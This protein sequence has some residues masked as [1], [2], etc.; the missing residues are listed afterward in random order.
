M[1]ITLSFDGPQNIHDKFRIYPN[2]KGTH[3]NTLDAIKRINNV[4][5]KMNLPE[6]LHCLIN[7]VV[8]GGFNY[9]KLFDYFVSIEDLLSNNYINFDVRLS[10]INDGLEKWNDSYPQEQL[11][12]PAGFNDL[13]EKNTN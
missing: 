7:C 13:L 1:A 4:A 5:K 9:K 12:E 8:V 10:T 6:T 2:S 3:E 11:T